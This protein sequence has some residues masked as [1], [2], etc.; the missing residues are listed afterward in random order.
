MSQENVE[1]VMSGYDAVQRGDYESALEAA[2]E[3]MLWDMSGFGLPDLAKVYRG[4]DGLREFWVAW[5][6][7]W[8]TIEFKTPAVEDHGEHVIVEVQQRNLGRGSG[9]PVDFHYF[10]AFT[11]RDGKITAS[12]MAQTRS[13]ALEAVG[14]S[15]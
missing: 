11:V 13:K 12:Y 2:D 15:G 9:I 5:L 10:Q 1:L 14:L 7:A 3:D 8:E 4:H 6:A